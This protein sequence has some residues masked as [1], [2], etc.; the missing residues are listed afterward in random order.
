MK[1][2]KGNFIRIIENGSRFEWPIALKRAFTRR[3]KIIPRA[4]K[5]LG[6]QQL[7]DVIERFRR[8]GSV[9]PEKGLKTP[10]KRSCTAENDA[11]VRDHFVETPKASLR[12]SSHV[13]GIKKTSLREILKKKIENEAIKTATLS[14]VNEK[15]HVAAV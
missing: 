12:K 5:K 14:R 2:E 4:A 11:K 3:F 8:T 1:L 10:Q 9:F 15:P 7:T 6:P 13:L